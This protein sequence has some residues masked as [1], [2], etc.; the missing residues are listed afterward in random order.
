MSESPSAKV[1]PFS[2]FIRSDGEGRL[3]LVVP[4]TN[5]GKPK[6]VLLGEGAIKR[7]HRVI[8]EWLTR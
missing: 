4:D 1:V 6:V 8:A 3:E 5:G 2:P 7:M